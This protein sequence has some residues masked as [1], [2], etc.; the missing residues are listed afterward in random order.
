MDIGWSSDGKLELFLWP[1]SHLSTEEHEMTKRISVTS[2][3]IYEVND[4]RENNRIKRL[5]LLGRPDSKEF[6]IYQR[7]R[8][9]FGCIPFLEKSDL[10][11]SCSSPAFLESCY[12]SLHFAAKQPPSCLYKH[13]TSLAV[14]QTVAFASS[15]S[16]TI[17]IVLI[18]CQWVGTVWQKTA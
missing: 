5:K 1:P 9:W 4:I 17:L 15:L 7:M 12:Q 3:M 10:N 18:T 14:K 6:Y 16:C 11:L 13:I 2:D 8:Y